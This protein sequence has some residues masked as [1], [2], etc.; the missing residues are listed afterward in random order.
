[1]WITCR[2][3][4]KETYDYDDLVCCEAC[5]EAIEIGNELRAIRYNRQ[6]AED[7]WHWKLGLFFDFAK[8]KN[9]HNRK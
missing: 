4:H 7:P 5:C 6:K 2:C 3:C 8:E 9:D 1:M